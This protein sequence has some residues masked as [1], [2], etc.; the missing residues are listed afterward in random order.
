MKIQNAHEVVIFWGAKSN[1]FH[2]FHLAAMKVVNKYIWEV[3]E[4]D[5]DKARA[6]E[7]SIMKRRCKALQMRSVNNQNPT[8]VQKHVLWIIIQSFSV[9]KFTMCHHGLLQG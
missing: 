6:F 4:G 2:A 5:I 9:R 7:C 1:K 8:H 3:K